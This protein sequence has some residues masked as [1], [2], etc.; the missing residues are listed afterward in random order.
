VLLELLRLGFAFSQVIGYEAASDTA[1]VRRVLR[2]QTLLAGIAHARHLARNVLRHPARPCKVKA[3]SGANPRQP[4][5][6]FLPGEFRLHLVQP[7]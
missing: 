3:T 1:A 5:W 7:M 4:I 6:K 2:G